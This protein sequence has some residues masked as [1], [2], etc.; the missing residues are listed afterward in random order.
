VL[1]FAAGTVAILGIMTAEILYPWDYSAADN[2]LSELGVVPLVQDDSGG[3][4]QLSSVAAYVF[5]VSLVVAGLLVLVAAEY[6]FRAFRR[7]APP[8]AL[9]LFGLG[10]WGVGMF[11]MG[12][13]MVHDIFALLTFFFGGVSALTSA[14]VVRPPFRYFSLLAGALTLGLVIVSLAL[15]EASPFSGLGGGGLERWVVYPSVLWTLGCGGYLMAQGGK[16]DGQGT[17][18]Q[19]EEP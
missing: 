17:Q 12:S 7:V 18:G 4:R 1:L 6:L 2:T 5:N 8:V 3:V 14:Q 9:A 11:D 19:K 15:Q 13:G 10:A 16:E